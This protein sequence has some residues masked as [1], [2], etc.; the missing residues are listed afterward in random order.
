MIRVFIFSGA[1][2]LLLACSTTN[3]SKPNG[4]HQPK[5]QPV[6]NLDGLSKA[7]FA[8]GCFWCVEAI[9]ESVEGVEEAVSGYSGGV[10][11]NPTYEQCK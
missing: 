3:G 11:K 10:I 6:A 4:Q 5:A 9:F 2:A 7:Y 1:I 8:S